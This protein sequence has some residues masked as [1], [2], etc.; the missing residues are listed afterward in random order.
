MNRIGKTRRLC[1]SLQTRS[2]IRRKSNLSSAARREYPF[3][4]RFAAYLPPFR[5]CFRAFKVDDKTLRFIVTLVR[6]HQPKG[7][8]VKG[9]AAFRR[10]QKGYASCK[11]DKELKKK[12]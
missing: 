10:C 9:I 2:P 3:Q 1:A 4:I 8:I 5:V 12:I 7:V 6:T 11:R